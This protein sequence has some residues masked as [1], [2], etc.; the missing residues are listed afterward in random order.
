M[1]LLESKQVALGTVCPDFNLPGV[2]GKSYSLNDFDQ[3]KAL[4]VMFICSHCP[5]VQAVEDR[6]IL[7]ARELGSKGVQFVGI[8]ANDANDYPDDS[9]ESLKKRWE[10]KGYGFPYLVDE[11]QDVAKAF[12]AVCTPDI[13][14]YNQN[15]ELAYRGRIDDNW[16]KPEEVASQELK[17]ALEALVA[18]SQ[19]SVD[20]KPSMG[21]SIK[22]KK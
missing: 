8:C 16:Q 9:F 11:S 21:C 22:W 12:Q 14:V 17:A 3:A 4:V 10:E 5:Y 20:Q 7:L 2:D 19:P 18:G 6:I 1:A 15:K 13:F